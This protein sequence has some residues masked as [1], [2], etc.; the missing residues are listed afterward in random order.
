MAKN[1]KMFSVWKFWFLMESFS[2][3]RMSELKL[4]VCKFLI[5]ENSKFS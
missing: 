4:D 5:N 3:L 1:L 2:Y